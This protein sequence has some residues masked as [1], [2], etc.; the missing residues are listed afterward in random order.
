MNSRNKKAL[1]A[2]I[3]SLLV[4]AALAANIFQKQPEA[5]AVPI[6][7]A[8]VISIHYI[9]VGQGDAT[10]ID[11]G[12]EHILID[13]GEPGSGAYRY[14]EEHGVRTLD[15]IIA[16]HPDQDHI[17]GLQEILGNIP[18]EEVWDSG[19]TNPSATYKNY[20]EAITKAGLN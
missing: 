8:E 12:E 7:G 19:A 18:V 1:T 15:I 9:D 17:G 2:S 14:L 4:L 16:T 11:L 13:G 3:S 10:L 6:G 5:P 20:T